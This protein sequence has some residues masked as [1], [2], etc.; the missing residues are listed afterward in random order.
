MRK[1]TLSHLLLP[2]YS[3]PDTLAVDVTSAILAT[4][5]S[6]GSSF[7]DALQAT[8]ITPNALFFISKVAVFVVFYLAVSTTRW[9]DSD[10]P[11]VE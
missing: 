2:T 3:S 7:A 11:I 5:T 4:Q 6:G 1:L 10:I 8:T 9:F